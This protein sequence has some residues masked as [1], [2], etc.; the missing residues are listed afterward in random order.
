MT[1]TAT[2]TAQTP[3]T[4]IPAPQR[5]VRATAVD[6]DDHDDHVDR[7]D[8]VDRDGWSEWSELIAVVRESGHYP[9]TTEAEHV[10]RTVLTALGGQLTGEERVAL[11]RALPGKAAALIASQVPALRPRSARE[12]VDTIATRI[13]GAT[14]ATA[15]WHAGSVLG[16]LP[17]RIGD[18]LT[19]R[20]L[21]R[22]PP[23]YALLFGRAELAARTA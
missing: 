5:S 6:H 13:E 21:T 1:T 12:F 16:A 7:N 19:D 14:P 10:T 18:A 23:G 2:T 11:A 20:I 3:R 22:L 4:V 15:R 8:H 9:T 17:P